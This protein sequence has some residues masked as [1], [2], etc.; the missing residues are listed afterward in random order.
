MTFIPRLIH[1]NLKMLS[2]LETGLEYLK[3]KN[4]HTYLW[5]RKQKNSSTMESQTTQRIY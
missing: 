2:V 3:Q 5:E 1:L 4:H